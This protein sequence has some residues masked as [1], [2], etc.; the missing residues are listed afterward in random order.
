MP[1]LVIAPP[2]PEVALSTLSIGQEEIADPKDI[3]LG[4]LSIMM[5]LIEFSEQSPTTGLVGTRPP[6]IE[7]LPSP[8]SSPPSDEE[9]DYSGDDF[10]FGDA[11]PLDTSKFSYW[12][13]ED[14]E[15][16]SSM[17]TV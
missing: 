13:A 2:Q 3:Q 9:V 10:D 6:V 8:V 14:M 16:T 11:P 15:V 17:E 1:Q 7:I 12:T 4:S 5:L